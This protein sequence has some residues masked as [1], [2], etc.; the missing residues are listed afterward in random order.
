MFKKWSSF[1]LGQINQKLFNFACNRVGQL[2][3]I[4]VVKFFQWW[5]SR[6]DFLFRS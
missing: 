5:Y 2:S 1:I 6:D 3:S 4:K